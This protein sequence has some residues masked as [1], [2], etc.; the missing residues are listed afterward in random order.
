MNKLHVTFLVSNGHFCK[1]PC[2][3]VSVIVSLEHLSFY[4]LIY[5]V[6]SY[7]RPLSQAVPRTEGKGQMPRC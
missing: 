4:C 6:P 5:A 7:V 1:E 2:V 3:H